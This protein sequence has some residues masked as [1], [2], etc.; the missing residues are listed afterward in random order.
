MNIK[1]MFRAVTLRKFRK[2]GCRHFG[3]SESELVD[4]ESHAIIIVR[5]FNISGFYS[6]Y[7]LFKLFEIDGGL[8][9][10]FGVYFGGNL[11][12]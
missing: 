5:Y 11:D 3:Q 10:F 2:F 6:G 9:G 7:E 12:V 8:S 1:P 4:S